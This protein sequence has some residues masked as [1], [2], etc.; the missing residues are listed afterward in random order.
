MRARSSFAAGITGLTVTLLLGAGPIAPETRPLWQIPCAELGSTAWGGFRIEAAAAVEA[1][2]S[3]PAHCAVTGTIDAEIRFELLLPLPEAWNGRFVMGGGGGFVGTLDNQA[4]TLYANPET[5]LARGFATVGT[6]TGHRGN[7]VDASWALERDDREVNFAHRAIHVTAEAAKTVIRLHYGRDID[8]SYF[9]G[10]SR[11]GGQAMMESQRY[12]DDFDGIVAGAP[13]FDWP[14]VGAHFVQVQQAMYP[15]ATELSRPVVTAETRE[16]LAAA[17]LEACDDLD[18]L[19]DGILNDP[20]DCDFRPEDLPVCGSDAGEGCVTPA[21]LQAI[22]VVYRGAT[23]GGELIYPGFPFGGEDD[24]GGWGSWVAGPAGLFP[25]L[26]TYQFAFGTQLY[27]YLV[28]DDPD[29]DYTAYDFSTWRSDTRDAAELL[30]ATDTDLSAFEVA[31]GKLILWT[32]WSDHALSALKTIDYYEE[33]LAEDPGAEE[34]LR[35]FLAPGVLHCSGGP[36]PDRVDWLGAVQR[37]VEDGQAPE[38]VLAWKS[39]AGGAI[40]MQRPLCAYPMEARYA[41]SGD[42]KQEESFTCGG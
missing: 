34:Y 22:Q 33:V 26:P 15:N 20:R 4:M 35:L 39:G 19:A 28:F 8:Y 6:D 11:G 29:W 5:P 3:S 23:S 16:L 1:T 13:A 32:G 30:N 7:V 25:G 42:P 27:K 14:G 10:C 31:G 36:G 37:W 21:E 40:E 9:L 24:P 18:G 2:E 41:G 38:R 17:I 12:P